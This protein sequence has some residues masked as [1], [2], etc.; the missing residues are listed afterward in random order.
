[1]RALRLLYYTAGSVGNTLGLEGTASETPQLQGKLAYEQDLWGKAP[2]YGR[3][4][5]FVAQVAAGWQR[6]RYRDNSPDALQAFNTF[7]QNSF[8]QTN[9]SIQNGQQYL[10]P[11]AIQGTLFIPVLPTYSNNLAGSAS[12]TAQYFIGQ[13]VSFLSM[14]RDQDNSWFDFQGTNAQN[15]FVYTRKLMQQFGGYLQGQ[16]WFTNQ[17]FVNLTWGLIRDFG[18]DSST[19]GVLA[20]LEPGN[21]PG[22]KYASANDQVKLWQEFDLSLWYR[23]IEALKFGLQYCYERTNFLQNLNN[24]ALNAAGSAV[25]TQTNA[26]QPSMVLRTSANPTGS[27]SWPICSSK[28]EMPDLTKPAGECPCGLFFVAKQPK[29]AF[30]IDP[31]QKLT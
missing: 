20:G 6:T 14:G 8:G 16:Y 9:A 26:V 23:P 5:G 28:P 27:S 22:Y 12:I 2:F 1:M 3:P 24:P 29:S 17:W 15:Q 31:N 25:G 10:D 30:E 7:G 4:R 21:R 18:I 19:S 11:W 13:G